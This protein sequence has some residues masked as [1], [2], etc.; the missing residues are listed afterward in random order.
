AAQA[1]N[2]ATR[3]V[4]PQAI[5]QLLPFISLDANTIYNNDHRSFERGTNL[6][7]ASLQQAAGTQRFDT[8][9]SR[10]Y[11]LNLNQPVFRLDRWIQLSQAKSTINQSNA[12]LDAEFQDL[13]IRT[14]EA[15]FNVLRA[16]DNV[17]F[18]KSTRRAFK[19]QLVQ[20]EQRFEV[21]LIAI[22]DVEE[23]KAGFDIANTAVIEAE[24]AL[25]TS[26]EDLR[27]IIGEYIVQIH[28]LGEQ[29]P[30][31]T[32][33]PNNI[34]QWTETALGQNRNVAAASYRAETARK[35]IRRVQAD[36]HLPTLDFVAGRDYTS[37]SRQS[38]G[39][40]RNKTRNDFVGLQFNVPLFQG[41]AI[42]SQTREARQDYKGALDNLEQARRLA[43]RNAR[44]FFRNVVD[45]ISRVKSLNQQTI[46]SR[47]AQE[48]IE[49]GFQVGTRT[50]V[51][52][53]DAQRNTNESI[54]DFKSARYDYVISILNLK[55]AAGTLSPDDVA[56]VNGWLVAQDYDKL[57]REFGRGAPAP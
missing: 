17:V 25:D 29:M 18:T 52:V 22:T 4:K 5:A 36:G 48:A 47:K 45:S 50:S 9:N 56:L 11:S 2:L 37:S 30:L 8:Y 51:D 57:K 1:D 38:R 31:V 13:I 35:E 15:Y 6:S 14:S 33:E 40:S 39:G 16:E 10:G 7:G 27:A 42:V 28:T 32:P 3:E 41:G 24:N 19:Q 44:T 23:A 20:A 46:S 34:D 49:A 12:D 53:L 55:E 21:G 54:R 26:R 43:Q